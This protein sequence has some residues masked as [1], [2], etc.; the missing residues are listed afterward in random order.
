MAIHI[1]IINIVQRDMKEG[2]GMKSEITDLV[3]FKESLV[4]Q[5]VSKC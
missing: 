2:V 5:A 3:N 1:W 4:S